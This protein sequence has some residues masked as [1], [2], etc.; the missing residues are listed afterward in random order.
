[1]RNV[2]C[3]G[4]NLFSSDRT[5]KHAS[6]TEIQILHTP[7]GGEGLGVNDGSN[8]GDDDDEGDEGN[9]GNEG[10]EGGEGVAFVPTTFSGGNEGGG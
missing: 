6:S 1:M 10:D 8:E 3:L 4:F 9:E 5:R 2:F 7:A